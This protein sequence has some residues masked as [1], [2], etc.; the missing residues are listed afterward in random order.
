[1]FENKTVLI[2]GAAVGIGKAC[3]LEFAKGGANLVLVDYNSETL[4]KTESEVKAITENVISFV[5]DVSD[6]DTVS[7]YRYV[8]SSADDRI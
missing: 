7:W 4:S 2:T 6:N 1:M 5:C 8:L 3:A